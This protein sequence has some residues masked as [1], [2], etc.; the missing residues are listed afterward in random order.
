VSHLRQDLLTLTVPRL[1]RARITKTV[2][3]FRI[4]RCTLVLPTNQVQ[5]IAIIIGPKNRPRF[6]GKRFGLLGHLISGQRSGIARKQDPVGLRER[7]SKEGRVEAESVKAEIVGDPC[8]YRSEINGQ[9]ANVD[10]DHRCRSSQMP[11]VERKRVAREKVHGNRIAR[12][13]IQNQNVEISVVTAAGL[14][15]E[16]ESRASPWTTSM[17][18][19]ES[20][21][22]VKYGCGPADIL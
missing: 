15:F 7:A 21:R 12:K 1:F 16:R 3:S 18:P 19:G 13:C 10:R 11:Y 6:G 4:E 5:E 14:P 8:N 20:R 9:V 17:R 2:G 22:K